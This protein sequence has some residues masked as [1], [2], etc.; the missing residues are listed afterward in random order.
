MPTLRRSC[1]LPIIG[2]ER[3]R[4]LWLDAQRLNVI[5]PFG[6]GPDAVHAAIRQLGYVQI[7]T[8]NVI[9]RCHHHMLFNRIPAYRRADLAHALGTGRTVFEYWTHALSYLPVEDMRYYTGAMKQH[10]KDPAGWG[11]QAGARDLRKM[12]TRIREEG[13][14]AISDVK[15]DK[16]VEKAHLW[17]SRKPSKRVLQAGFYSGHL[18]IARREGMLKT[19][20]LTERHFGWDTLPK[21]AT[22]AQI[23][24]YLLD[25]ALTSQGVVSLDSVCFNN[26][27]SKPA[28]TKSDMAD[29]LAREA[30]A[31]RLI[32]VR[33]EGAGEMPFWVRPQD[34]EYEIAPARLT[35]I[36]SP[37]DPMMIQRKRTRAILGYAH[38]FEAYV[39]AA[40]R[41]FGYFTLPVLCGDEIVA[42]LDL[43]AD[44]QTKN[45]MIQAW[46]WV[47]R[48]EASRHKALIETELDRFA[49]FQF[50]D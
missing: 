37:F 12:L 47:G 35:H 19:Y 1:R 3:A 27:H 17:A 8:I 43:K 21:P 2:L 40:K 50:A 7:D 5:A 48:G 46:H 18:V 26:T 24:R 33:L 31:K 29:L 14:L 36:L 23:L 45:L 34:M 38:V 20:E 11:G 44:R 15:D 4:A 41:Q 16:L 6:S 9:E 10:R 39:P 13:P 22:P 25:R 49:A 30:R 32:E 42:A 28:I